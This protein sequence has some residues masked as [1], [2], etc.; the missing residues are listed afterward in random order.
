MN[1]PQT[2]NW[3]EPEAHFAQ[4]HAIGASARRPQPAGYSAHVLL[5]DAHEANLRVLQEVLEESGYAVSIA[6]SLA[7][8]LQITVHR[9][10]DL[11]LMEQDLCSKEGVALI[12]PLLNQAGWA[13]V[14]CILLGPCPDT[15]Q[16]WAALEAGC[17]DTLP[18]PVRAREVLARVAI[19]LRSHHLAA[20][21]R[22]ARQALDA[23][24]HASLV[25]RAR[26]GARIWHTPLASQLM[27]FHFEAPDVVTPPNVLRWLRQLLSGDASVS[28]LIT[29]RAGRRLELS[30]HGQTGQAGDDE[31]LV[32]MRETSDAALIEALAVGLKL[33]LREAEVLYWVV[34]GK[35]NRD[36]AAILGLS[37]Q[38]VKKHLEHIFT[39]LGVETRTSAATLAL[40]RV[41][42][43]SN[44]S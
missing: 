34:K 38:T 20:Q 17:V 27:R 21:A 40:G 35:I 23:F 39:K 5:I 3:A 22:Q 25:L 7:E 1:S 15:E 4:P 8:A 13:G 32:V 43:L 36:I 6:R 37:P 30:L 33:T 16:V 2:P 19:H 24:G 12:A 42:G 44:G 31:W 11:V 29:A 18:K 9:R 10:P 14:P 41:R 26:D 28:T